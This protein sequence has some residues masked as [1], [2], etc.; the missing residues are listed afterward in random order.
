MCVFLRPG[1]SLRAPLGSLR[2]LLVPE[3][4]CGCTRLVCQSG[5]HARALAEHTSIFLNHRPGLPPCPP[6]SDWAWV[7]K[8]EI[9][10]FFDPTMHEV[11]E[12][13][14]V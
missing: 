9:K 4:A 11:L 12:A 5:N 1:R 2:P 10:Q 3:A 6:A 7:S 14:L 13:A 8:G